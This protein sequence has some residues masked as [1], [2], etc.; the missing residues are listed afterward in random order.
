MNIEAPN[1]NYIDDDIDLREWFDILWRKKKFI[2]LVTTV[3]ALGSVV[4]ALNLTN[5]YRSEAVL[6]ITDESSKASP[7]QGLSGIASIAG[8]NLQ[9]SGQDKSMLVL[10]TL[11]SRVFLNHLLDFDDVLPSLMAPKKD[12]K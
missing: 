2:L 10:E 4:Y 9:N 7:L 12:M 3:F 8:L 11:K 6:I 5:Y 1:S